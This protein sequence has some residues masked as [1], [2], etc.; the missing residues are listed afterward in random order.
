M[1]PTESSAPRHPSNCYTQTKPGSAR[2]GRFQQQSPRRM[3]STKRSCRPTRNGGHCSGGRG[4]KRI[5]RRT[6]PWTLPGRSCRPRAISPA[7][8]GRP[9][10]PKPLCPSRQRARH[11]PSV[12]TSGKE[13]YQP[14]MPQ[15][16]PFAMLDPP[17]PLRTSGDMRAKA[18]AQMAGLNDR[19]AAR[20]ASSNCSSS[21]G[22]TPR[23][24]AATFRANCTY[25]ILRLTDQ[26]EG[27]L[28]IFHL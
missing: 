24:P 22:L 16:S 20:A 18:A 13:P 28:D 8:I 12:R 2:T 17:G 14:P 19:S 7:S 25:S 3:R 26:S 1:A 9:R 27:G 15:Q 4:E 10:T 6:L 5:W 21:L 11:L 23:R